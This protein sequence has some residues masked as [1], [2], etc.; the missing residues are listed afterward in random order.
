[1]NSNSVD[2][3]IRLIHPLC[4]LFW[5]SACTSV[6]PSQGP[7]NA[8]FDD[9][10]A[11]E[12]SSSPLQTLY[13][14]KH[15]ASIAP[16]GED[17]YSRA[18]RRV[19]SFLARLDGLAATDLSAQ[20]KIS[21][22]VMR[23]KLQDELDRYG[24]GEYLIPL[25]AESGFYNAA[26]SAVRRLPFATLDD[27]NNW[28]GW[29][30][31]Y[32]T[33]LRSYLPLLQK[34]IA[35]QRV[36][37]KKVVENNIAMLAELARSDFG[38]HPDFSPLKNFPSGI[39]ERDRKQVRARAAVVH[40]EHLQP[41]YLEL[42]EFFE[43]RYLDAAPAEVGLAVLPGGAAHYENRVRFFTSLPMSADEVFAL[44]E[45][46]VARIEQL[47]DNALRDADFSGSR[48]EFIQHLKTDPALYPE[49]ATAL[50]GYS[51]LVAKTIEG[52]LPSYFSPLYQLPFTVAPV[53]ANIAA[54][55]TSGRYV[56]G[57]VEQ[58][59]PGIY[60][61]NTTSL[62]SR[63]LFNVPALTLHESVPGH[64]LQHARAAELQGVHKFRRDYYISAFGEGWGLYA[65]FLGEEMGIYTTP[66][67][68]FGR[69]SYEMWR[70]CRLVIDVGLHQRGWSREKAIAYMTARTALSDLEV[71]N[72]IDRYIGWPGQ[73]LSYKLGELV[74]KALRR[75][76]EDQLGSDFD[77]KRF[78]EA[79]L[80][81]GAVPLGLLVDHVRD[82][83]GLVGEGI[84]VFH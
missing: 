26:I 3:V 78:H 44:G 61:V 15:P 14:G 38:V 25:S 37:P 40:K 32:A 57:D 54:T 74:I 28:L 68:R 64:H 33:Y 70:A 29:L 63:G 53:P 5:L 24:F 21:T 82:K 6:A 67:E 46:E 35:R 56:S 36:P 81:N 45:R 42:L 8:L 20:Q 62:A 41:V 72:E 34:G 77:I 27:Y 13:D 65:E 84:P 60:W 83:L 73:A 10:V 66:E 80:E 76:S 58:G 12:E 51:A 16:L 79:V 19:E 50:L 1:L 23:Y 22:A 55:Y 30:P 17:H 7:F 18:A 71:A 11:W 52:K 48:A 59:R 43:T 2:V 9:V 39:A 75:E 49:S 4:A 31:E 69:L 47:M